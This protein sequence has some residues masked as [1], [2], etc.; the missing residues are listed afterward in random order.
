MR[1]K[2]PPLLDVVAVCIESFELQA[3]SARAQA[4]KRTVRINMS[5]EPRPV[6]LLASQANGRT[7]QAPFAYSHSL[8]GDANPRCVPDTLNQD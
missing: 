4:A 8:R 6:R 7:S 2:N 1:D 3:A 5:Y